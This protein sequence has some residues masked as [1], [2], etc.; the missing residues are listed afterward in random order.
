MSAVDVLKISIHA[1]HARSDLQDPEFRAQFTISIHAPHARSDSAEE[2]HH[3]HGQ[4]SI[5]AP[6]AR[7]DATA[8]R[9][10]TD[11][12]YFNPRSSCE[13][14]L[15]TASRISATVGFQ[16]TLLMRGAT[17]YLCW[18]IV[19][20]N[21][22]IHAPHARSDDDA[23]DDGYRP[24]KFQSTLL[25]R[26]AT[27]DNLALAVRDRISIHA[28]HARSDMMIIFKYQRVRD[29]NPRSSCEERR[30]GSLKLDFK[31]KFQSTLL[32]RGATAAVAAYDHFNG[33]SIH[34]PHAR[35]D[36]RLST[37]YL[38]GLK[39]QS[40]LLMRG[41]TVRQLTRFRS[42]QF[43]STLLMR[44]ATFDVLD[45]RDLPQFQS[46]L[47]MRGATLAR[48]HTRFR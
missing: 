35:S 43:Q 42:T 19:R 25:M 32:M 11:K 29:F 39:F 28:P 37:Q 27:L 7:S 31:Q 2:K 15:L 38:H 48:Y 47:L 30:D 46:T 17:R 6:H 3:E 8:A 23:I 33:I 5:H 1:P 18:Y 10:Q 44:G 16:S 21:I 45:E 34:A 9:A 20:D 22:S 36:W 13:E 14:R 40:T 4:I 24:C 26:G 41:A 12:R